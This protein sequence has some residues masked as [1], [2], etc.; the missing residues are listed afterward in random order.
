V[1]GDIEKSEEFIKQVDV[2][3]SQFEVPQETAVAA[4]KIARENNV[5]T[6][7]NPAPAEKDKESKIYKYCDIP[8]PNEIEA[9]ILSDRKYTDID[10]L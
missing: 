8:V 7:L 6:I 3:I 9:E 2:L 10:D 1:P 4:F 5:L